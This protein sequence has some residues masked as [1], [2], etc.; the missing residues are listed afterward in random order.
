MKNKLKKRKILKFALGL[1]FV[2]FGCLPL[3]GQAER[4]IKG[5]IT[6]EKREPVIGASVTLKG[7]ATVGTAMDI[8]G[9]FTLTVPAGNQSLVVSYLGMK[10]KEVNINEKDN[11]SII[12]EEDQ[13]GLEEVVVVGYGQQKKANVVGAITQTNAQVLEH[14]AGV[15][16]LGQVLT[17]NLPGLITMNSTGLP[18]D[19]DPQI[20][21]RGQTSWNNSSP[22][23]LVDG[24]VR[25]MNQ[26]D[27][28]SVETV[29]VLKDASAT[30]VYGVRGAN[31]VI[32][33]TTKRGQ[34]GRATVDI[35]ANA[36]M[37][38]A[39]KLP[40]KLDAYDAFILKDQVIER[41][42]MLNP[43]GWGSYQPMNIINKYRS[44]ANDYEWDRYPNVDWEKELLNRDAMSYNMSANVSGGTNF[45]KY[46]AGV[47]YQ[48]DG[49]L[50]KSF[51]S[52]RGYRASFTFNR[53]NESTNN[54]GLW[55]GAYNRKM[56][57]SGFADGLAGK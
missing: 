25:P 37:R 31:G 1:L 5:T 46:F 11:I 41:E 10:T 9:A 56:T 40:K 15:T 27:I 7:K 24:I 32:L 3:F 17:G 22:L 13:V 44:P 28:S 18:G 6:D 26:V 12:L 55:S 20:V 21:I 23:I 8:N 38:V 54:V 57:Y 50:F 48:N 39:S 43:V 36:T 33:I 34:E 45:V 42:L 4:T 47:D 53:I 52:G 51:D 49:D 35:R 14:S 29:S 2:F 16:S 19:E 30:A